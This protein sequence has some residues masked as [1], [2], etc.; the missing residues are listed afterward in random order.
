MTHQNQLLQGFSNGD[1]DNLE[2]DFLFRR[3]II[4]VNLYLHILVGDQRVAVDLIGTVFGPVEDEGT[5]GNERNP[6]VIHRRK[7]E[8]PGL[9]Y[10]FG[11]L[12]SSVEVIVHIRITIHLAEKVTWSFRVQVFKS[13]PVVDI[14]LFNERRIGN[15]VPMVSTRIMEMEIVVFVNKTALPAASGRWLLV[16]DLSLIYTFF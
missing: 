14:F 8:F 15:T 11:V 7:T 12:E 6:R 16:D 1:S 10:Q 2:V 5:V 3:F 13:G 4:I 9:S